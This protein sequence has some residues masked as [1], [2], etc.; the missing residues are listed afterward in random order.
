MEEGTVVN[1]LIKAA[2]GE[3]R[4]SFLKLFKSLTLEVRW[5]VL[6]SLLYHALKTIH[7]GDKDV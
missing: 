7:R 4:E 1:K 2:I 3:D 6:G 5:N